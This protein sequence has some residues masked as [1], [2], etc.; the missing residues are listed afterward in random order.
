MEI[1]LPVIGNDTISD[2]IHI[3]ICLPWQNT[4]SKSLKQV[5]NKKKTVLICFCIFCML[6]THLPSF[7]ASKWVFRESDL[8]ETPS[9]VTISDWLVPVTIS[10]IFVVLLIFCRPFQINFFN[11]RQFLNLSQ[12]NTPSM[13]FIYTRQMTPFW[14]QKPDEYSVLVPNDLR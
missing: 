9:L 7:I 10:W 4:N 6:R 14:T 13:K 8:V 3:Q 12:A 1:T 2:Y 11:S 5:T